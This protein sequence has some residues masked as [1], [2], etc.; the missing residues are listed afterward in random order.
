MTISAANIQNQVN[1][2]FAAMGDL[3]QSITYRYPSSFSRSDRYTL[4]TTW[5]TATVRALVSQFTRREIDFAGGLIGA[6]DKK[7]YL[8]RKDLSVEITTEGEFIIDGT[9]Y[10]IK[11][12]QT[13]PAGSMYLA[14]ATES[15]VYVADPDPEEPDPEEPDPEP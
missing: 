5:A 1:R 6:G 8:S 7:I 2:A 12:V 4:E 9:I 3:V 11:D 15:G 13:D 14:T 10:T